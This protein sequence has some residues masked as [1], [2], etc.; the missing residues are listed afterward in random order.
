MVLVQLPSGAAVIHQ[1]ALP[2]PD[3]CMY[4]LASGKI[5]VVIAGGGDQGGRNEVRLVRNPHLQVTCAADS[6]VEF[7]RNKCQQYLDRDDARP[8]V[9]NS[10]KAS[11]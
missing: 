2:G 8:W 11:Q 10:L 5:D 1:G 9:I 6:V 7:T 3:D 4:L